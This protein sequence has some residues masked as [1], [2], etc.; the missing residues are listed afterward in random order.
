MWLHAEAGR[1][2]R[3]PS[4]LAAELGLELPPHAQQD[5]PLAGHELGITHSAVLTM[6]APSRCAFPSSGFTQGVQTGSRAGRT[7]VGWGLDRAA[8]S[9][10]RSRCSLNIRGPSMAEWWVKVAPPLEHSQ[11]A[12]LA[13]RR[14]EARLLKALSTGKTSIS[15]APASLSVKGAGH[16]GND[17]AAP[18]TGLPCKR[19]QQGRASQSF[20]LYRTRKEADVRQHVPPLLELLVW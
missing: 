7:D 5:C 3:L 6:M 14:V 4:W 10:G 2:V 19:G 11:M 17:Q 8:H 15:Q 16:L 13:Y 1:D 18:P 20:Q 12:T 9:A